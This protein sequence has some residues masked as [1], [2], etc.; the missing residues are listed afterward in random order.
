MQKTPKIPWQGPADIG[1]VADLCIPPG[2]D[3]E[4]DEQEC[5]DG[6]E[7]DT[8]WVFG[9]L[10]RLR[11]GFLVDGGIFLEPMFDT[12]V[13][14]GVEIHYVFIF[15]P[16]G[17]TYLVQEGDGSCDIQPEIVDRFPP[18]TTEED[19]GRWAYET[20]RDDGLVDHMSL[21]EFSV[22]IR[23][24]M[25]DAARRG[26]VELALAKRG[27]RGELGDLAREGDD[28]LAKEAARRIG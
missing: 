25:Q 7:D 6:N 20:F 24:D 2:V 11:D 1:E 23:E 14:M 9:W 15:G 10:N 26:Y 3:E 18:N 17:S 28:A 19:F 13:G 8:S 22:V 12:A 21:L 5:W 16:D 27:G 4:L